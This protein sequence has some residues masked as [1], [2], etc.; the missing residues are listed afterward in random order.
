MNVLCSKCV[1][2]KLEVWVLTDVVA[3][4]AGVFEGV[5]MAGGTGFETLRVE[6]IEVWG[7]NARFSRCRPW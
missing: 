1:L 7:L 3:D 2:P 6:R 4:E 5:V